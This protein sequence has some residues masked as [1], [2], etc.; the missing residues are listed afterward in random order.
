MKTLVSISAA[1][2]LSFGAYVYADSTMSTDAQPL[3]KQ[4]T[5]QSRIHPKSFDQV[6][7][8]KD[9]QISESEAKASGLKLD[10]SKAD[11]DGDGTLSEAEYN[12][13]IKKY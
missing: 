2:A 5:A 10:W 7:T 12:H 9:G 8:N 11:I 6:D 3:S 4:D 1:V 13:A